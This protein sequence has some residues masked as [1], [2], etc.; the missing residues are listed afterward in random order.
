MDPSAT[1]LGAQPAGSQ[2]PQP[3]RPG[4]RPHPDGRPVGN[5]DRAMRLVFTCSGPAT[6]KV[7]GGCGCTEGEA[8]DGLTC[9]CSR[10][11]LCLYIGDLADGRG[12]LR[13]WQFPAQTDSYDGD[14][15]A[16]HDK[17]ADPDTR[18]RSGDERC[19][20]GW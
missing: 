4:S 13:A 19:G 12:V 1:P 20:D 10:G 11:G 2:P 8:Q 6:T 15:E 9:G 17:Q 18:Q 3:C 5:A 16:A 7:A 14:R